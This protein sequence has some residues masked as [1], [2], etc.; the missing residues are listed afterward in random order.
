MHKSTERRKI[1]HYD[2]YFYVKMCDWVA[3]PYVTQEA[4]HVQISISVS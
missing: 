2:M 4:V 1:K 3:G